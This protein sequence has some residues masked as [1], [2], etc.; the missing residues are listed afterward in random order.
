MPNWH[1]KKKVNE[2]V[3]F[4]RA[5][6]KRTPKIY[7]QLSNLIQKFD[8]YDLINNLAIWQ[9]K[10]NL[11]FTGKL[12]KNTIKKLSIQLSAPKSLPPNF[13]AVV[14]GV[15]YRG[16]LVSDESQLQAL[17]ELGIQRVVSLHSNPDVPRLCNKMGVEHVAAFIEN[18]G[19]EDLGR[20]V[21]G[22]SVSNF[23]TEKPTYVHCFFGEDRTGGVIARFRTETGWPCKLAYA[24]AK[25]YGF[26]DIFVDLIDW[27]SEFCDEKPVDTNRI[28]KALGDMK[29]YQNPEITPIKEQ[30]C[31]LTTPAPDD[32]PYEDLEPTSFPSYKNY[33]T[34]PIPTSI[35]TVPL[36]IRS[37]IMIRSQEK[38][39]EE[40]SE[41]MPEENP[42]ESSANDEEP[43]VNIVG[44][45]ESEIEQ[46][47]NQSYTLEPFFSS[48][49][50]LG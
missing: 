20:K 46:N 39:V 12:D 42:E 1:Q 48:I 17:K 32:V 36:S 37:S 25:H 44:L 31:T 43:A 10:N 8:D 30:D 29:P 34:S 22:K 50:D 26:K 13:A 45:Q 40:Y 14:P 2:V 24:E 27:F 18:G 16:G 38:N 7:A 35:S 28:R 4:N 19:P 15:L 6:L 41:E 23:L 21:F 5:V 3:D 11:K 9:Y 49:G 33:I 47:M